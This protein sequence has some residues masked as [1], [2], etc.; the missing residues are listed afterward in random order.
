MIFDYEYDIISE[1]FFFEKKGDIIPLDEF[2]KRIKEKYKFKDNQFYKQEY[3]HSIGL[4][5]VLPLKKDILG[6]FDLEMRSNNYFWSKKI[7][8]NN[9]VYMLY[10]PMYTSKVND[11]VYN[12]EFIYH[13]TLYKI[14]DIILKKGLIPQRD[15]NPYYNYHSARLYFTT[16]ENEKLAT[17]LYYNL[18]KTNKN[19]DDHYLLLKI[20]TKELNNMNFYYDC[21][22]YNSFFITNKIPTRAITLYKHGYIEHLPYDNFELIK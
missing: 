11:I 21:Y 18:K 17:S 12:Q 4:Y 15:K 22:G 19:I 3:N 13:Y 10:E 16:E 14:M 8:K 7:V 6:D 1:G 9:K 2:A 5:V 20:S